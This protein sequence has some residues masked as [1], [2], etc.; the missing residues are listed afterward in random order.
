MPLL[1]FGTPE[2][3]TRKGGTSART[4]AKIE[5][6]RAIFSPWESPNKQDGIPLGVL[7]CLFF[8]HAGTKGL[9]QSNAARMSAAG[10]G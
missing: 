1:F 5:S 9:E 3:W 8:V 6:G 4:G 7:A 2:G 10:E